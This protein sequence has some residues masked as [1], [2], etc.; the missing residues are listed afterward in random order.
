MWFMNN[1]MISRDRLN[2]VHL[3]F[4]YKEFSFIISHLILP[5]IFW[6]RLYEYLMDKKIKI[7]E[8]KMYNLKPHRGNQVILVSNILILILIV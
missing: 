4:Q 2:K 6:G 3:D 5:K 7:Q 1:V 8:C